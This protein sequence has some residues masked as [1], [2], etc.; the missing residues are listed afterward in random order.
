MQNSGFT[1]IISDSSLCN[2]RFLTVFGK[3]VVGGDMGALRAPS[4]YTCGLSFRT[5]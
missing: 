4:N 5:K 1:I 3:T 2:N